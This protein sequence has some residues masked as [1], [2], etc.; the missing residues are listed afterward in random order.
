MHLSVEF[1]YNLL[2]REDLPIVTAALDSVTVCL[3]HLKL[4]EE[5]RPH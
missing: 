1:G 2:Q 3:H 4:V 5:A